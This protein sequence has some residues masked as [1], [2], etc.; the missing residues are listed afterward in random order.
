MAVAFCLGITFVHYGYW[1]LIIVLIYVQRLCYITF[2]DI[3]FVTLVCIHWCLFLHNWTDTDNCYGL[4]GVDSSMPA[5]ELAEKNIVLNGLDSERITFLKQDA[6]DFMKKAAARNET[7][8]IVVLDPPK[9]APR[10]EVS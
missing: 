4:Q 5:L 7:W 3:M 1:G 8:D 10:K 2:E 6:S 9:L